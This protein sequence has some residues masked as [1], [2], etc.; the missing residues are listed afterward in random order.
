M[1]LSSTW[2][3]KST[4]LASGSEDKK[5]LHALLS[6]SETIWPVTT[7][8]NLVKFQNLRLSSSWAHKSTKLEFGNE[9]KKRL[10]TPLAEAIFITLFLRL[11]IFSIGLYEFV[12]WG[13]SLVR[14]GT[15]RSS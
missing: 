3:H 12:R 10:Y 9:D 14:K 7:S 13:V 2:A 15:H 11:C 6:H 4:K 1:C 8:L 5:R